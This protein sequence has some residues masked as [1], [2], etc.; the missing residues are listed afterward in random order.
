[1]VCPQIVKILFLMFKETILTHYHCG[2]KYHHH[3]RTALYIANDSVSFLVCQLSSV[4]SG[5]RTK[6]LCAKYH[7]VYFPYV[8]L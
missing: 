6:Y 8:L 3:L 4:V 2:D 5:T 1:M 7:G